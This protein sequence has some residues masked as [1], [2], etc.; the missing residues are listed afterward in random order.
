M[1]T[2]KISLVEIKTAAIDY[3]ETD[4]QF[5]TDYSGRWMMGATCFGLVGTIQDLMDFMLNVAAQ[6]QDVQGNEVPWLA[7]PAQDSM[8]MDYIFYW[9]NIVIVE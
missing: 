2:V 9:P 8:G 1:R 5:R 7:C 3:S 6:I 4:F